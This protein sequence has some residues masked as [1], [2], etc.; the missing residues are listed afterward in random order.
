M[1]LSQ[2]RIHVALL[3]TPE[4]SKTYNCGGDSEVTHRQY[5]R[6]HLDQYVEMNP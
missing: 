5:I 4:D 6:N 3:C 1:Q 2:Y